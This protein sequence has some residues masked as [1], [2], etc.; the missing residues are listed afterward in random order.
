MQTR[1]ELLTSELA[2][3]PALPEDLFSGV[4]G[5][6]AGR[7]RVL[8]A[9]WALA[10]CLLLA[11]GVGGWRMYASHAAPSSDEAVQELQDLSDFINGTHVDQ[12]LDLYASASGSA[13]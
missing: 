7:R 10:V 6:I 3:A 8:R 13:N 9:A 12:E 11:A 1:D 4:T 5:R 2:A